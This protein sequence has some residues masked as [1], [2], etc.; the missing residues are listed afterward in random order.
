MTT[1]R[2]KKGSSISR[3]TDPVR[4]YINAPK[5]GTLL[6]QEWGFLEGHAGKQNWVPHRKCTQP[7]LP[8]CLLQ[9]LSNVR[10]QQSHLEGRWHTQP[11]TPHPE[12]LTQWCE[13]TAK[14]CPDEVRQLIG[15]P[16]QW[17]LEKLVAS[18]WAVTHKREDK[19][20]ACKVTCKDVEESEPLSSIPSVHAAHFHT[21]QKQRRPG[22]RV[23]RG[24]FAGCWKEESNKRQI[25]NSDGRR[26]NLGIERTPPSLFYKEMT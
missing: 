24:G 1:S 14:T 20:S 8:P 25:G 18:S 3:V 22:T 13:M 23:W 10:D 15:G 19:R 17:S 12:F 11:C 9:L 7:A 16:F 2:R 26:Y 6:I 5:S 4:K 21:E